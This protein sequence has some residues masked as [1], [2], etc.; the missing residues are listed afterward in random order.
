MRLQSPTW[1]VVVFALVLGAGGASGQGTFQNLDFESATLVPVSANTVQFALAFPGWTGF[2]GGAQQTVALHNDINLDTSGISVIDHGWSLPLGGLIQGNYT[3][4][5]QAGLFGIP[6]DTTLSQTRMVPSDARSLQF[7]VNLVGSPPS[8]LAVMLGGQQLSL[9]ALGSGSNYTMY[10]ADVHAWAGQTAELD[11]TVLAERP[12][13]D[14]RYAFLDS[15][16][17]SS[18]AVPEP[19]VFGL[20]ALGAL[21]L[22]WRVLGR[23]R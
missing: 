14:N 3:A 2:I 22:G 8:V 16:Q 17:F 6:S 1:L 18:Q 9:T 13:V 7:K 12:H 21:L 19:G 11:F 15:I 4:I 10:G 20:S 5:L 23:R